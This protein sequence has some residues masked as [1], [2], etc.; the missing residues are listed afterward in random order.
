MLAVLA[1]VPAW[2]LADGLEVNNPEGIVAFGTGSLEG[3]NSGAWS[4]EFFSKPEIENGKGGLRVLI[5]GSATDLVG[6]QHELYHPGYAT[7]VAVYRGITPAK[8]GKHPR[9]EFRPK[10]ALD[11]D[12]GYPLFWE[13]SDLR[14]LS[15]KNYVPLSKLKLPNVGKLKAHSGVPPRGPQLVI[16]PD[17]FV[18]AITHAV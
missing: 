18:P 12:T 8:A 15:R 13:V 16:V 11:D 3:N 9:P 17:E 4:F 7:A 1:P 2:I 10:S 6:K 14:P 5:Y